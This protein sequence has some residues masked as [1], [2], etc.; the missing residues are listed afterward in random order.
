MTQTKPLFINEENVMSYSIKVV[1]KNNQEN[2]TE[3]NGSGKISVHS[4]DKIQIL[5]NDSG[6]LSFFGSKSKD[7]ENL[8][9][10]KNG[11][12][13]VI[14]LENGDVITLAN[15]YNY[16]NATS[17]EF[18][19]GDGQVH[20]LLSTDSSSIDMGNGSFLVYTQ[21]DHS[22]LIINVSR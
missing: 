19:D 7:I 16:K 11:N 6:I 14:M 10:I 9:A 4:A 1:N 22:N 15:F 18:V 3:I 2:I 13:L 8:I 17:V 21:G 5:S 20:T 12:N